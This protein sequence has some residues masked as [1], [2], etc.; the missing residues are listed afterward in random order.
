MWYWTLSKA[1][2]FVAFW[3]KLWLAE[4]ESNKETMTLSVCPIV[5]SLNAGFL[6]VDLIHI[7]K[8]TKRLSFITTDLKRHIRFCVTCAFVAC[9]GS[10]VNPWP[11]RVQ[12]SSPDLKSLRFDLNINLI[13]E[14]L[15]R[16]YATWMIG[17]YI[18]LSIVSLFVY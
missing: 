17:V 3:S 8:I 12:H 5:L 4:T 2:L 13:Y 18:V 9:G 15:Y 14:G 11:F 16:F 6:L 7:V 10:A 1:A